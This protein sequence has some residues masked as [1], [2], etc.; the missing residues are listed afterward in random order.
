MFNKNQDHKGRI[1]SKA[2]AFFLFFLFL[3][4]AT[5]NVPADPMSCIDLDYE[6]LYFYMTSGSA[7][8][9]VPFP[10][11]Q[12]VFSDTAVR[13]IHMNIT[14]N[15]TELSFVGVDFSPY[16]DS[17][18]GDDIDTS[19]NLI[20]AGN[21]EL[22]ISYLDSFPQSLATMVAK[23]WLKPK[24]FR[25]GDHSMVS[26]N[27]Q[28]PNNFIVDPGGKLYGPD[29][30][31]GYVSMAYIPHTMSPVDDSS[32]I[33]DTLALEVQ[34]S[35]DFT[36]EN[37]FYSCWEY[38]R[39]SLDVVD[40]VKGSLISSDPSCSID[41]SSDPA[42]LFIWYTGSVNSASSP[43]PI[44]YIKFHNKMNANYSEAT[45]IRTSDT[46]Y[47]CIG[48]SSDLSSV[49]VTPDTATLATY[50]QATMKFKQY[51][52]YNNRTNQRFPVDLS[53][54][55]YVKLMNENNASK[56]KIDNSQWTLIDWSGFQP[57]PGTYWYWVMEAGTGDRQFKNDLSSQQNIWPTSSPTIFHSISWQ[58]VNTGSDLGWQVANILPDI[59]KLKDVGS[60]LVLDTSNGLVLVE[61]SFEVKQYYPDPGCPFVFVWNGT[62]FEEDNTILAASE[63]KPIEPADDYYLLRKNLVPVNDE[64]RIQ[65]REF[66]NEV[67]YIDQVRLVA[68]DHSPGIKV[69]VTPQGK[70]FGYEREFE[71]VA[72]VDHN[73]R[74]RL[75]EIRNKDG[76]YF[77]S[78][79][80]GYL[81]L[82]CGKKP[83]L[84]NAVYGPAP[85]DPPQKRYGVVSKLTVEIEDINGNWH[86]LGIIPP[87]FFPNRGLWIVES[88]DIELGDQFK[89]KISWDH[90]YSVDVLKYYIKSEEMPINIW[91]APVHAGGSKVGI[92]KELIEADEEYVTLEP[93]ETIELSFPV[94]SK[95]DPAMVRD[96]ILQTNG[97]YTSLRKP[98]TA[99]TSFTLLNNY[100]NPFNAST[101]ILYSLPQ[102]TDVKL[103]IFNLLGQKVR[104]LVDEHQNTG[105]KKVIWDG[106][107]DKGV[108]VSSGIYFYRL[109]T[110]NYSDSKKMVLMR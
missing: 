109:V 66:E 32:R 37:G 23:L 85:P 5:G 30:Y 19:Y 84:P 90:Y 40:V 18:P 81:V 72:C 102:A 64:Y 27:G 9:Q 62:E 104:V 49:I 74:D 79:E 83:D 88:D 16:T 41:V 52:A 70:I 51:Y 22:E 12:V 3:G 47:I 73:G 48:E 11:G 106:K 95:T 54:N 10:V 50:Y 15:S 93:G 36:A 29:I 96:F 65:I 44:Y 69:A 71:P 25:S 103:E 61:D 63:I 87:R 105:Y 58:M 6:S 108:D 4:M 20:T 100:P 59:T 21:V 78:E 68:V 46:L 31:S 53:H 35:Y 43:E 1:H 89:V 97:Y 94:A 39:D 38:S 17:F 77:E 76:I 99:P 56:F 57:V 92:L 13:A 91:S 33:N 24:C 34:Y 55:F 26:Y 60:N 101:V 75:A 82:T 2:A 67:S 42:K 80:P 86:E 110:E 107:D 45:I 8:Y 7:E 14:W 98:S 28:C